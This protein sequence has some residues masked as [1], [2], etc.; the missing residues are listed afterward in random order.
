MFKKWCKSEMCRI[1]LKCLSMCCGWDLNYAKLFENMSC[2]NC[3]CFM[4]KL[5]FEWFQSWKLKFWLLNE[6]QVCAQS[7]NKPLTINPWSLIFM[8]FSRSTKWVSNLWVWF[9]GYFA[10]GWDLVHLALD[11]VFTSLDLV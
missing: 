9:V 7:V 11:Y 8:D 10:Y 3:L 4:K 6:R 1:Y 5:C 2:W